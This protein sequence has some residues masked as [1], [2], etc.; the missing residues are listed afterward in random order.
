MILSRTCLS[1]SPYRLFPEGT[2]GS[3][4]CSALSAVGPGAQQEQ[5]SLTA[6]IRPHGHK[7]TPP[8]LSPLRPGPGA[9]TGDPGHSVNHTKTQG[10][11][12]QLIP[13]PSRCGFST[14]RS[15]L[16]IAVAAIWSPSSPWKTD[17]NNKASVRSRSSSRDLSEHDYQGPEASKTQCCF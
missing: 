3:G 5:R 2:H 8:L 6:V 4:A 15:G 14:N 16:A 13:P 9:I 17:D 12:L 1:S 11:P 7:A 10:Y